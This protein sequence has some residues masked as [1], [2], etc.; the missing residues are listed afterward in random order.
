M[1][2]F[3]LGAQLQ[4]G[5][6]TQASFALW[7]P[8]ARK[9]E[10]RFFDG[11][12]RALNTF[13]VPPVG[14]GI[15]EAVLT[16]IKAGALY[17]WVLDGQELTDPYARFLP[18]G[19]DGPA[20]VLPERTTPPLVNRPPLHRLVIYEMHVGTF[21]PEGTYAAAT[22][23]LPELKLLGVNTLELM[24]LSS[25]PGRRGWGYDGVA[26]FAPYAPYGR[27]EELC[28][29]VEHAHALGL[30]VL[31]DVVYNHFGPQGCALA[32]TAAEYF[33]RE[34][35][36]WGGGLDYRQPRMR[37]YALDNA[38]M[39][40]ERYGFDGLRLDATH[41]IHDPSPRH[42]LRE[43]S[44]PAH[45][46]PQPRLLIAE[47]DR[48]DP[49]LVLDLEVDAQWAD[50]F[51]HQVHVL[52]TGEHDGYYAGYAPAVEALARTIQRGWLYEGEVYP[53]WG[54]PRGRPA[55]ALRPERLVYSLQNHDQVGNRALGDRLTALA[56][57]QAVE[58]ATAL[59]LFL[60]TIRLLFMGQE[61]G[62]STP[63]L[64]FCDHGPELGA[65]ISE[66]RRKELASFAS[67]GSPAA[68]DRIPD[69]Q[70]EETFRRSQLRWDERD[71]EPHRRIWKLVQALL[72]LRRDDPVLNASSSWAQLHAE[73]RGDLL[74]VERRGPRGTRQLLANFTDRFIAC[75]L[76]SYGEVLLAT[77]E[78]RKD[79]LPPRA[80]VIL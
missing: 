5:A 53:A 25:F 36:P 78:P 54:R 9:L 1:S 71:R 22:A 7:A 18:F 55:V 4:P 35:G 28:A 44:E 14:E 52:L 30:A 41:A 70:S 21:T 59:L 2:R 46:Y 50:D 56:S 80:A 60:P 31:A 15:F 23:R 10:V 74:L 76:A 66:G 17:K 75:D 39:W 63:F 45:A 24:P 67:F 51:H 34:D 37:A 27:P 61:W 13:P 19:V 79:G 49:S 43:L 57:G 40:F 72:R 11:P 16:G 77:A 29:F 47:D 58:A 33:S 6:E 26:H 64:F 68:R 20:E 65:Q 32:A 38:R 42:I 69:P 73:A 3:R 12:H 8:R 48:N 62:A